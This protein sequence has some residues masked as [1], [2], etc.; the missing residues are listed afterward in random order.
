MRNLVIPIVTVSLVTSAFCTWL[1]SLDPLYTYSNKDLRWFFIL[2]LFFTLTN[3]VSSSNNNILSVFAINNSILLQHE[4][5]L[6][7]YHG[8]PCILW[9]FTRLNPTIKKMGRFESR[10]ERCTMGP[11]LRSNDKP[12][13]RKLLG[14]H[15]WKE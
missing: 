11:F 1:P 14:R 9:F 7:S 6:L 10:G 4:I 8:Y 13:T 5:L 2:F 15:R 12:R 3:K